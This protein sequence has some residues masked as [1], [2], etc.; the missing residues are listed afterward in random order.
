MSLSSGLCAKEQFPTYWH[1]RPF[2]A[3][4]QSCGWAWEGLLSP[5]DCVPVPV[6][7]QAFLG[8]H[9]PHTRGAT[10][11]LPPTPVLTS[12]CCGKLRM[13]G[14]G[15]TDTHFLLALDITRRTRRSL[16]QLQDRA[17]SWLGRVQARALGCVTSTVSPGILTRGARWGPAPPAP[18]QPLAHQCRALALQYLRSLSG[19][20]TCPFL[21]HWPHTNFI[22]RSKVLGPC[23]RGAP[24][25]GGEPVKPQAL[26]PTPGVCCAGGLWEQ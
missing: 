14:S 17:G 2:C 23:V 18:A 19:S 26:G 9:G 6:G 1:L 8:P 5:L 4:M 3:W 13:D 22:C 12:Y 16:V 11:T 7:G 10:A 20:T 24:C 15:L 21:Q 25:E